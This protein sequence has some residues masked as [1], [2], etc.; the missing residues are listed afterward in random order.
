MYM[1]FRQS[2]FVST[3]LLI[4]GIVTVVSCLDPNRLL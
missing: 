3:I 2:K 1:D 4:V